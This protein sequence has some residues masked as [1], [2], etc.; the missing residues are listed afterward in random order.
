M[1]SSKKDIEVW[2]DQGVKQ[3]DTHMII[4]CDTFDWSDYPIYVKKGQ[5]VEEIVDLQNGNNM[6][7][8]VEVYD[9]KQDKMEQINQKVAMNFIPQKSVYV[10]LEMTEEDRKA[11][12]DQLISKIK[13]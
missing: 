1:A 4:I 10:C 8:V 11:K 13:F 9:L 5:K 6:Q 3:D 7:K 12:F 2:F